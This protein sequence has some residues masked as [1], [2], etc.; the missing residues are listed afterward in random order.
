MGAATVIE[1]RELT[2]EFGHFKAV[3]R[4][5]FD[6]RQ[7]EIFGFLGPNGAGKSTTIRMLCGLL[8][9]TSGSALVGG[10]D[11]NRQPEGVRQRIGYMSQ[12]FSLYR[13]L[14]VAEN[15]DFFGGVYGLDGDRLRS[16]AGSV[17]AMAGLQGLES[18]M[19]GTLSGALQ[20]RLALGCALL[21]EPPI[22][23]LDEPT[24]GVD[25]IS[26]RVFWDL[27]QD[28]SMRGVTVLVTTH[29]LDEAEF[30]HRLGFISGGK[31]VALN[32]PDHIK[33][34]AVPEDLFELSLASFREGREQVEGL[35]G[36]AMSAYFGTKL[37][38]FCRPGYYDEKGLTEALQK[39]GLVVN[40]LE[41][42]QP[43]LEDCFI[44]LAQ[45]TTPAIK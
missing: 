2:K 38:L 22:L 41:R 29:F 40:S 36:V 16:R 28:L 5:S 14:T 1:A 33:R 3:D 45:P 42:V 39:R 27:I 9:S 15:L 21:H 26:R 12:R 25:P 24:S 35:D 10:C 20:Q 44:R 18:Q 17:I 30:C 13:D 4:L 43:R 19:T 8:S 37:H 11:I 32:T 6:V 23:F 7:G 34:T 31:L